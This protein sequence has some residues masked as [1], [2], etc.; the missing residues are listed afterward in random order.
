MIFLIVPKRNPCNKRTTDLN[1]LKFNLCA[2]QAMG[3]VWVS[4]KVPKIA[5]PD[6]AVYEMKLGYQHDTSTVAI[7]SQS[8]C[9]LSSQFYRY[10]HIHCVIYEPLP[11]NH[12]VD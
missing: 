8:M 1:Y 5:P 10:P 4:L 11:G 9:T 12:T 6:C 7:N 3:T 2:P